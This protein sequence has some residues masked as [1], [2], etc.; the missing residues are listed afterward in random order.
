METLELWC[1]PVH[2]E[3]ESINLTLTLWF[4][5]ESLPPLRTWYWSSEE[6]DEMDD[7]QKVHAPL[8]I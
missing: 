4:T 6:W 1:A 5:Y 8:I 3:W 7:R 2:S